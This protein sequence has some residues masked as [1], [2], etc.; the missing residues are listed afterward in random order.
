[1]KMQMRSLAAAVLIAL[2]PLA[3]AQTTGTIDAEVASL[4]ATAANKGQTQVATK[5]AA[6][7]AK[8]AGSEANAVKLVQALRNGSNATLTYPAATQPGTGTGTTPPKTVDVVIDPAT[9]KMGWGN[10]KISLALA[11]AQLAKLGVTNPTAEQ[12]NAAL[13]G[14]DIKVTTGTGTNA[15]TTTTTVKGVL[16]MRADGMGWGQI[17]KAGGTKVGP[18][19]SQLKMAN[20]KVA[21]IPAEKG[22]STTTGTTAAGT[23]AKS[24]KAVTTAA[25]TSSTS[26]AGK[27]SK[28]ITTATGAAS[29]GSASRGVVTADGAGAGHAPKGNGHGK[30]IVS[31]AGGSAG[32]VTAATGGKSPSGA[33]VVTGT[34]SSAGAVS[35]AAGNA[36]GNGKG[37]SGSKGPKV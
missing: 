23:T 12:L 7:F 30:G 36:G 4:D 16:Q 20:T 14:G 37:N 25:G 17:A 11:Q 33:G 10:V 34:G 32:S 19:V 21:A 13:N 6:N 26:S 29:P 24:G 27:P 2:S 8:L 5:I 9:G 35:S 15:T 18:V 3:M 1:M 22:T 28:G 31:A